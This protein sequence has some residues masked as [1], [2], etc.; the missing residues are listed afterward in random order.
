M[1]LEEALFEIEFAMIAAS[2][3]AFGVIPDVRGIRQTIEDMALSDPESVLRMLRTP[4][5]S[6]AVH[7]VCQAVGGAAK[8]LSLAERRHGLRLVP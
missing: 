3:D 7:T 1:N 6:E 8:A 5:I 2:R 4:E